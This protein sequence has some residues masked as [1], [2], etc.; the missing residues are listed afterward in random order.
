MNKYV[1]V[2]G[3][4]LSGALAMSPMFYFKFKELNTPCK[5]YS[6][7]RKKPGIYSEELGT[8]KILNQDCKII[9]TISIDP[10]RQEDGDDYSCKGKITLCPAVK[11]LTRITVC[12][13]TQYTNTVEQIH[14]N[15]S[16][17]E[18]IK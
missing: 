10:C 18:E 13:N 8:V 16:Y 11:I 9:Q 15:K 7:D 5:D 1:V 4:A 12:P 3:I 17:H 14:S 2:I 6:L